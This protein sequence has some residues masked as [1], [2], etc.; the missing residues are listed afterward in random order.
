MNGIG[1]ERIM[2][3]DRV[4]SAVRDFLKRHL[5]D[6]D[7]FCREELLDRFLSEMETVRKGGAG[8][9]KMIPAWIGHPV[10]IRKPV[11]AG[12]R[13]KSLFRMLSVELSSLRIFSSAIV[14]PPFPS[15]V[16]YPRNVLTRL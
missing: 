7:C 16:R 6:A 12:S 4:N 11:S 10:P 8:S 5:L 9:V 1:K 15:A 3:H 2:Q 13:S 14:F